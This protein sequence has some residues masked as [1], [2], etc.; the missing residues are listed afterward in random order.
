MNLHYDYKKKIGLVFKIMEERTTHLTYAKNTLNKMRNNV[1]NILIHGLVYLT[2]AIFLLILLLFIYLNALQLH[3]F[4]DEKFHIPQTLNYC[5]GKL[6][7]WDPK[8]TTLPG[9]YLFA[10]LI[11]GPTN[12]CT[13]TYLRFIN[14]CCTYVN[15][16]LISEL[17]SCVS[18]KRKNVPEKDLRIHKLYLTAWNIT[19][20]PPLFFWFFLYYTDTFSVSLTLSML[21]LHMHNRNK[22]AALMGAFSI[23]V[24]QTNVIW[25][26]F[27]CIERVLTLIEEITKKPYLTDTLNPLPCIKVLYTI[28]K[29]QARLGIA[30]FLRFMKLIF[31]PIIP[32]LLVLISFIIFVIYNGGVVVGDRTAHVPT[33]HFTQTFYFSIFTLGFFKNLFLLRA[34]Q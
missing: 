26:T 5:K 28:F 2:A 34:H 16:L 6:F 23:C 24:R 33:I 9:L 7:E 32:Y 11:F 18:E 27:V 19:F 3:Y 20:F 22:T 29:A 25:V 13:I 15:F 8:I 12:L 4:I 31:M 21:L 14:V 1:W 10:A 17:V 30:P